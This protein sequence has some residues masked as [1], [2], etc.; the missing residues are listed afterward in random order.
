[1][2]RNICINQVY[3]DIRSD[4]Q[5]RLLWTSPG[6]GENY[7]YWLDG[8]TSVPQKI[9][10]GELT[11]GL[12]DGWIVE[13]TDPFALSKEPSE[14][15][16]IRR[17]AIWNKMKGALQEEPGIYDRKIRTQ[18][19]R[20]IEKE[21]NESF[22]NLYR[23]LG[24][25]WRRGKT[26]DAFLPGYSASGGRGK[27]RVGRDHSGAGNTSEFGK[28]LEEAD[29]V[30][31]ESAIR[32]YYLTRRESTLTSVFNRLLEDS[33]TT[34]EKDENGEEVAR[35]LPKG[36]LPSIRQFRY[37]YSH[38]RNLQEEVTKRKGETGFELTAR[39]ATGK[40]DFGMLGPG[41]QYQVD[42]T[43][44]DVYLVSQFD[45]SDII[46]RPV[47][48]FVMDAASRIVTGMYVGLEGPSWLGMAMALY[49]ATT[50]KVDY[51]HQF[52]IEIT[53]EQWPCH[54]VPSVLLGDRGEL[55]S[56]NADNLVSML[57]IRVDNAPPYRGDLKPIIESHFRTIHTQVKPLLPGFVM[58]DDRQRGG[59]DY[60]LDAKLDIRQFTRIII[61]CVL[62]YNN[63]HYL[64][65]FEKNE[66]MLK[67]G[68]EA[69][70]IELWKW[71][72]LNS[73]GALR[74]Y[75]KQTIQLALMPR[76]SGS[77][78]E[79][80]IYFRKLYYSCPEARE[81]LWFE[82]ARKNGRYAV[83]VSYD[84]RDMSTIY[85]WEKD[86][87]TAIPCTLLDWEQ[88]FSGK[89]AEEVEFEQQKRDMQKK[90]N[91]RAEKDAVINLNRKIE[92]IVEEANRMAPSVKGKTRTERLENIRENRRGEKE[93]IRAE[94]AFTSGNSEA[95]Q[96]VTEKKESK[97]GE[98]YDPFAMTEE[99]WAAMTPAE[100]MI[101]TDV[102]RR[103]QNETVD[104]G[105]R[106]PDAGASGVSG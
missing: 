58:P 90:Q 22:A 37:W 103:Q 95:V 56:H 40:N 45:R 10:Y 68:V 72:I 64:N 82:S 38:S 81:G 49:N 73:S 106:I 31:F 19:L 79:K 43:V 12:Q 46:G 20:Q 52:G 3:R 61:N 89:S 99:E 54:H 66:Q 23:H 80:G 14:K 100:R 97:S 15:D 74:T 17:D 48:Y 35:L 7:I 25:Y 76:E 29:F 44:A 42:A 33:Y 101:Y 60:R 87:G 16:K 88:R 104:Q 53:E 30:N 27:R 2:D 93:A 69:I 9:L 6:N 24:R 75:P 41:S 28:T 86:G 84:T 13:D 57:G 62:Y 18:L 98:P 39:A 5:F 32:K 4:K 65:G 34:L 94:E 36:E 105:S 51:C 67:S 92:A 70:P 63:Q 71:G 47:M 78:T 8:K 21:G 83:E 50:D 59:R 85:V 102:K 1:M 91:E 55:E 26:P 77:V 11:A 96:P